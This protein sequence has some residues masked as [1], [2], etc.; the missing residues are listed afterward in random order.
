[1]VDPLIGL[2]LGILTGW[3]FA[4]FTRARG[5]KGRELQI[6]GLL[7]AS[8]IYVVIAFVEDAP[9]L[10]VVIEASGVLVFGFFILLSAL[11]HPSWLAW[12]WILH[13]VWDLAFHPPFGSFTH[14]PEWYV[15]TCLA[16]DLVVGIAILKSTTGPTAGSSTETA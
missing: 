13:P 12:G 9:S 1:M 3:A 8:M 7:V 15:W 6:I 14:A 16:F 5:S 11:R 4:R 10:A 2:L